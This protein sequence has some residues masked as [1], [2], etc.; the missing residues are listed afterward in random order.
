[1]DRVGERVLGR[2]FQPQPRG[3]TSPSWE[4]KRKSQGPLYRL[5]SSLSSSLPLP[6]LLALWG[7]VYRGRNYDFRLRGTQR[8][9]WE[10]PSK[11]RCGVSGLPPGR[12]QPAHGETHTHAALSQAALTRPQGSCLPSPLLL[13]CAGGNPE[14]MPPRAAASTGERERKQDREI[15]GL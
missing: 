10:R 15:W 3:Q 11:I 13:V 1:M 14:T 6:G 7:I 12:G 5:C 9:G 2:E 8:P 4:G